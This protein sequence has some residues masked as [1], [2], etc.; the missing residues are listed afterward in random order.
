[1]TP[2]TYQI[3]MYT[4]DIPRIKTFIKRSNAKLVKATEKTKP[5][6]EI[7]SILNRKENSVGIISIS[8]FGDSSEKRFYT[9]LVQ[10]ILDNAEILYAHLPGWVIRVYFST[11]ISKE[12]LQKLLDADVEIYLMNE[13]TVNNKYAGLLWRFL[14]AGENKQFIIL[15]ADMSI[16]SKNIAMKPLIPNIYKW[17]NSNK[18][19]LRRRMFCTF[20]LIPIYAGMWGGKPNKENKEII[21]NIKNLME[22]YQHNWFGTDEAFLKT[23]VWPLFVKEGYYDVSNNLINIIKVLFIVIILFILIFI[24]IRCK[25]NTS[26]K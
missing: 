5:N 3:E 18:P 4:N 14:P 7:I 8:L 9:E 11:R 24:I 22:N 6:F 12:I 10:P 20:F 19:F 13:D 2:E 21:P 16:L 1:M 15:D 25:K 17:I 26:F 23:E